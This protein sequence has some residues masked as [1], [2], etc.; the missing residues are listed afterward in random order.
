MQVTGDVSDDEIKDLL[1]SLQ[2]YLKSNQP[3]EQILTPEQAAEAL[4]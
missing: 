3:P 2:Y 1:N 4:N